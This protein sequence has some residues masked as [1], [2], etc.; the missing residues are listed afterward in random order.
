MKDSL[1]KDA[2][3]ASKTPNISCKGNTY[4]PEKH[5]PLSHPTTTHPQE[6]N[7]NSK[8]TQSL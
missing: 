8:K 3:T 5:A 7:E 6:R 1:P 2:K 4:Q